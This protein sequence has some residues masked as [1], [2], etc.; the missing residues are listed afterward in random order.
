M[1]S[2]RQVQLGGMPPGVDGI[3]LRSGQH[4]AGGVYRMLIND[5]PVSRCFAPGSPARSPHGSAR[6]GQGHV[7][8]HGRVRR[9]SSSQLAW[10]LEPGSAV[11]SRAQN[12]GYDLLRR[13]EHI[14]LGYRSI[15]TPDI[16]ANIMADIIGIEAGHECP[17]LRRF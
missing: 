1:V 2:R 6:L 4:T 3:A 13:N 10:L 15:G 17:G 11:R 14:Q 5:K 7:Y 9:S 16:V 8:G 12:R